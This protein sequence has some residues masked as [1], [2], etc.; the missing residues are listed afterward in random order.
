MEDSF[1]LVGI[2]LCSW[3]RQGGMV[4][5]AYHLFLFHASVF[6]RGC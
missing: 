6:F 3:R 2:E 1:V 4:A 5:L